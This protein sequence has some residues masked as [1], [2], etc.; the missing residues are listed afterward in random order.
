[1]NVYTYVIRPFLPPLLQQKQTMS[2]EEDDIDTSINQQATQRHAGNAFSAFLDSDSSDDDSD[3]DDSD[4]GAASEDVNGEA[5]VV[6]KIDGWWTNLS[7]LLAD[8]WKGWSTSRAF[9]GEMMVDGNVQV[10]PPPPPLLLPFP[11]LPLP[12]PLPS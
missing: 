7:N 5:A 9:L 6:L 3:S 8:G 10:P 4:A 1:M 12:S 11:P 2:S